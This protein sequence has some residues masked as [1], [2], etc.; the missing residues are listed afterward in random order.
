MTLAIVCGIWQCVTVLT[1]LLQD[2]VNQD[3]VFVIDLAV[4]SLHLV[5]P[6]TTLVRMQ[7]A[8][9]VIHVIRDERPGSIVTFLM[10]TVRLLQLGLLR[11]E[12]IYFAYFTYTVNHILSVTPVESTLVLADDGDAHYNGIEFIDSSVRYTVTKQLIDRFLCGYCT[13]RVHGTTHSRF[14]RRV[15]YHHLLDAHL[16]PRGFVTT[17]PVQ[18]K[19]LF[20]V[21]DC[22]YDALVANTI[23]SLDNVRFIVLGCNFDQLAKNIDLAK[24]VLEAPK[25]SVLFKPHPRDNFIYNDLININALVPNYVPIESVVGRY[26][27]VTLVD[28]GSS[29]IV[30]CQTL[31]G[32]QSVSIGQFLLESRGQNEY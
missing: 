22:C 2:G 12:K 21:L 16:V 13:S 18:R 31:F 10:K 4:E 8:D 3:V 20:V 28:N 15:T 6:I 1:A 5:E 30:Q 24:C 29:A 32:V 17:L 19:R 11:A 27:N 14:L 25:G 7:F 23:Q 9:S 26:P